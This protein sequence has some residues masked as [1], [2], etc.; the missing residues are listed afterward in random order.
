MLHHAHFDTKGGLRTFAARCIKVC[1]GGQSGLMQMQQTLLRQTGRNSD[2]VA[3]VQH[4]FPEADVH[5]GQ[6]G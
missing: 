5:Y 6:I 4:K 3:A 1:Y 2:R